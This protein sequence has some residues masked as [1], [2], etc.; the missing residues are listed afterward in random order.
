M[1]TASIYIYKY[2]FTKCLQSIILSTLKH[3]SQH[4]IKPYLLCALKVLTLSLDLSSIYSLRWLL[5]SH[6][7]IQYQDS[8]SLLLGTLSYRNIA[9]PFIVLN[10]HFS[11]LDSYP[12]L[13]HL[14]TYTH[15]HICNMETLHPCALFFSLNI[16]HDLLNHIDIKFSQVDYRSITGN[17]SMALRHTYT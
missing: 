6:E 17:T 5:K 2:I 7:L 11:I 3:K 13:T 12:N 14:H 4:K 9:Y 8:D 15:P 16:L 1:F 10:L